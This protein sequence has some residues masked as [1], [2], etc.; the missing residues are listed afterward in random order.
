M[1]RLIDAESLFERIN[2]VNFAEALY[3]AILSINMIHNARTETIG[4]SASG[5]RK[6]KPSPFPL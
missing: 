3:Q 4:S 1:S 5:K 6:K 2:D